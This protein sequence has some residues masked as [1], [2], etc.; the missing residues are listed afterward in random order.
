MSICSLFLLLSS[1]IYAVGAVAARR[2]PDYREHE[3]Q[4]SGD[5]DIEGNDV[6]AESMADAP[7]INSHDRLTT[8]PE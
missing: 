7:L 1:A 4:G 2:S 8:S 3:Q 5:D 6:E